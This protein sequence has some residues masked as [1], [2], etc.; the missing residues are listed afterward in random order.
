M[1]KL[2]LRASTLSHILKVLIITS[3]IA[4]ITQAKISDDSLFSSCPVVD[5]AAKTFAEGRLDAA[6]QRFEMLSQDMSAPSF[7]RG[8]A[9][10]GLA[11]VALARQPSDGFG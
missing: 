8:L 5:T 7:A 2:R 10:F 9:L 11:E 3:A 6:I 4:V 1:L